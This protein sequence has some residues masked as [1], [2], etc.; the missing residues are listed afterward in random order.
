MLL[1]SLFLSWRYLPTDDDNCQ[2]CGQ[3][4]MHVNHLSRGWIRVAGHLILTRRD[5]A[6]SLIFP[7]DY[8]ST[9]MF[10]R[11]N[12]KGAFGGRAGLLPVFVEII[13]EHPEKRVKWRTQTWLVRI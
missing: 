13:K 6:K 11:M 10:W 3:F 8:D 1:S 9:S 12:A 4:A 2:C 7:S 5:N